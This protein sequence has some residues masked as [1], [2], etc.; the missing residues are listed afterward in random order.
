MR[1]KRG[2]ATLDLV[3]LT[4]KQYLNLQRGDEIYDSLGARYRVT[5]VKTWVRRPNDRDYGLK[6]GLYTYGTLRVRGGKPHI[7]VYK[8]RGTAVAKTAKGARGVSLKVGDKVESKGI[9]DW[10][11]RVAKGTRGTVLEVRPL[12]AEQSKLYHDGQKALLKVRWA[13]GGT[14]YNVHPKDIKRR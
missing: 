4:S 10:R 5:S 2:K 12:T 7:A 6:H 11:G 8:L 13:K 3:P 9:S 1:V 14:M